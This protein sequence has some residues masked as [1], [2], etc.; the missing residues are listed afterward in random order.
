MGSK[1]ILTAAFLMTSRS[2][3][4]CSRERYIRRGSMDCDWDCASAFGAWDVC[5]FASKAAISASIACV[6]SGSAGEPS[7]VENL[8]PLYS[9]GLCEGVKLMALSALDWITAYEMVGVGAGFA[10]PSG[11]MPWLDKISAAMAQKVSPRKRGSRPT[12]TLTLASFDFFDA[13]YRA[14]PCTALWT[15]AK[16]NSSAITARHPDV[17]NLICV[18]IGCLVCFE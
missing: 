8:M 10:I 11:V 14:M 9:G 12:M 4:S 18:A 13:T 6:T 3:I 16:V 5:G 17:P 7:G 1:A 15:L 2:T